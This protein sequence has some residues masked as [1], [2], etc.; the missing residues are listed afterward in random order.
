[1]EGLHWKCEFWQNKPH[2]FEKSLRAN[3]SSE[4]SHRE[5]TEQIKP[6]GD[7]QEAIPGEWNP[8]TNSG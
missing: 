1:M 2:P 6:K 3:S 4:V 8:K 5:S 7:S